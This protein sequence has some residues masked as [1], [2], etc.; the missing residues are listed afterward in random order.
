MNRLPKNLSIQT[1]LDNGNLC[2]VTRKG[3]ILGSLWWQPRG[4]YT[5]HLEHLEVQPRHQNSGLGEAMSRAFLKL[6]PGLH[7]KA[8]HLSAN[9][10]SQG[11][12]RLLMRVFGAPVNGADLSPLPRKSP[13]DWIY[14]RNTVLVRFSVKRAN[15][16][17]IRNEQGRP[18][19]A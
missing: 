10:T 16:S 11:V 19:P 8:R 12:A 5:V 7:P 9:A 2:V 13:K 6:L 4:K 1:E 17:K 15:L 14:A 18:R 3:N